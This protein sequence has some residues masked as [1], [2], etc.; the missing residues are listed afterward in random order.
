VAYLP[1][2]GR[3]YSA[4]I[5]SSDNGIK[6]TSTD[7]AYSVK[8]GKK[9]SWEI[10]IKPGDTPSVQQVYLS[11]SSTGYA[12]LRI[13]NTNRD[14]MSYYGYIVEGRAAGKKGF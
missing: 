11:I 5:N 2:Y 3:A 10:T 8:R 7:F 13:T 12:S 9:N 6:F 1:F 14:A 4:P